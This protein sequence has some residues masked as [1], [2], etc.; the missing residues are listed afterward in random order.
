[1]LRLLIFFYHPSNWINS[2]VLIHKWQSEAKEQHRFNLSKE[3]EWLKLTYSLWSKVLDSFDWLP[4]ISLACCYE[5]GKYLTWWVRWEP[6]IADASL[7]IQKRCLHC[8][9]VT[10]DLLSI[11]GLS[12]A[13]WSSFWKD[14]ALNVHSFRSLAGCICLRSKSNHIARQHNMCGE[15]SST[16]YLLTN[17]M[18]GT[19]DFLLL[20][21]K[22]NYI[23]LHWA[24][25]TQILSSPHQDSKSIYMPLFELIMLRELSSLL[26]HNILLRLLIVE[27][28]TQRSRCILLASTNETNY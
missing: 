3:E 4:L 1:M 27:F 21:Q 28:S 13:A 6:G 12:I 14:L 17:L 18:K 24:I 25:V 16:G 23:L 10:H 11:P 26:C 20:I 15:N 22:Q 2:Y 19:S 8:N 7:L 9:V 5:V